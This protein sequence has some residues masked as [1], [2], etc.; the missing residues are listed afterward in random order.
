MGKRTAYRHYRH[1]DVRQISDLLRI[2]INI[3]DVKTE[4]RLWTQEISGDNHLKPCGVAQRI[5]TTTAR[6]PR[7][8]PGMAAA[9]TR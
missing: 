8:G 2:I 9:F 7:W 3:D 4:R 1:R 5:R 6:L